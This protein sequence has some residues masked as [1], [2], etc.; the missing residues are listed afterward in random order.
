M[1]IAELSCSGAKSHGSTDHLAEEPIP[2]GGAVRRQRQ[3]H[4]SASALRP[5]NPLLS[6]TSSQPHDSRAILTC[7]ALDR[8]SGQ[9]DPSSPSVPAPPSSTLTN[10]FTYYG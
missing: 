5:A 4:P 9:Q 7:I 1:Q 3:K 10:T 6:S 2:L 8:G